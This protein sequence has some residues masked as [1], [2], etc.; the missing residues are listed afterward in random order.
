MAS[1]L[2]DQQLL[3][4]YY[5]NFHAAHPIL[6]PLSALQGSLAEYIPAQLLTVMRYI[7][8]HYH[9]DESIRDTLK[10]RALQT[11][12][13]ESSSSSSSPSSS[14]LMDG[15]WVQCMLLLAICEYAQDGEN[16][17]FIDLAVDRALEL[18]MQHASFATEHG[19][20]S[21]LLEEMWRRTYW[22][23][24]VVDV[25]LSAPRHQRSA[26]Y[27]TQSDVSLP[28]DEALYNEAESSIPQGC[29]LKDLSEDS[30]QDR[31]FSSFAY[32]IDAIRLLGQVLSLP[33]AA[34]TTTDNQHH[35]QAFADTDN[36]LS[37][38]QRQFP[39]RADDFH[40]DSTHFGEMV[41]QAQ[42]IVHS[43]VIYLHQP[44]SNLPRLW[45]T[46]QPSITSR[47]FFIFPTVLSGKNTQQKIEL[48]NPHTARVLHEAD[49][50][51]K[52]LT[53]THPAVERHSP[54]LIHGVIV[55]SMVYAAAYV[56][57]PGG[58]NNEL[59][60]QRMALAIGVLKKLAVM[61]P[62]AG[63]VKRELS[64]IYRDAV[65]DSA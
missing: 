29:L 47:F 8:A 7:G 17:R 24:Y 65:S 55:G 15:F 27:H 22:E 62:L 31:R 49:S 43:A 33:S 60:K 39:F 5:Q 28:C 10:A 30:P 38:W 32:R 37:D 6:L 64:Q 23:L 3:Q 1:H 4:L 53:Q 41:F 45:A 46:A 56:Q 14:A 25:L 52:L 18:G 11:T 57:S 19:H 35:E 48:F 54:F 21:P 2:V 59:A 61:W 51:T 58:A 36:A 13:L 34:T 63:T 26:L 20:A 12:F 44:S 50:L 16:R 42:M 40:A 9:P